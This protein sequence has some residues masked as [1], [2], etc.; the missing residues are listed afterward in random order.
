[1]KTS[2]LKRIAAEYGWTIKRHGS[3]H[4]LYGNPKYN[5]LIAIGRHDKEEVKTGTAADTI[6]KIKGLK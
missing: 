4:D 6:K 3:R 1:M 2:E 5:Y